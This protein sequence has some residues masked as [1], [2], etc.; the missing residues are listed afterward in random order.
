MA[1]MA[2]M[3]GARNVGNMT[4]AMHGVCK[5][6]TSCLSARQVRLDWNL[7]CCIA[8]LGA[9]T[10]AEPARPHVCPLVAAAHQLAP[11]SD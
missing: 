4:L 9:E 6:R 5:L 7:Q 1:E 8:Q 10:K 3:A 11:L 2:E